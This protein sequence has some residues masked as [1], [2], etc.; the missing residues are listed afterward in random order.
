[1]AEAVL[2]LDVRDR[3]VLLDRRKLVIHEVDPSG[4]LV[5]DLLDQ[6]V[7]LADIVT[8][9]SAAARLDEE[10]VQTQVT[11]FVSQLVSAGVLE[12]TENQPP[13]GPSRTG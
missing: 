11:D 5:L 2:R 4:R 8:T 6:E 3:C 7:S 12:D 10:V 13:R 9:V 1:M